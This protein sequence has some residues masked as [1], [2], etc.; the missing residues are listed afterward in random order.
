VFSLPFV[1]LAVEDRYRTAAT[2]CLMTLIGLRF[3]MAAVA[4]RRVS[5][6]EAAA[7]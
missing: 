7:R 2:G 1:Q 6:A 3:A 5:R 4:D